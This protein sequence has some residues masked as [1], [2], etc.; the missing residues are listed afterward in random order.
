MGAWDAKTSSKSWH[1]WIGKKEWLRRLPLSMQDWKCEPWCHCLLRVYAFIM[2]FGKFS[3]FLWCS[4]L[5]SYHP[6]YSFPWEAPPQLAWW[7]QRLSEG[8]NG[9][10]PC[11]LCLL[12]SDIHR[13]EKSVSLCCK[14][15][16]RGPILYNLWRQRAN[17]SPPLFLLSFTLTG[18]PLCTFETSPPIA[19]QM[20]YLD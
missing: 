11:W 15:R 16:G 2:D 12:P 19:T 1:L 13:T 14:I 17:Q 7:L 9:I 4:L 20:F 3:A 10:V 8:H 6:S 18:F 5:P